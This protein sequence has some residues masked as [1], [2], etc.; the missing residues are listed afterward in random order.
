VTHG[1]FAG[2]DLHS[3]NGYIEIIDKGNECGSEPSVWLVLNQSS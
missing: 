3:N 1:Y 2:V